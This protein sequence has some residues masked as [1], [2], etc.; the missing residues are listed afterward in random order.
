MPLKSYAW[1]LEESVVSDI[2]K[3]AEET[4]AKPAFIVS[5]ALKQY[6]ENY[7]L[8]QK[9]SFISSEII[10]SQK[11]MVDLL[12]HRIN[13]RA[14]QLLSSLAIQQFIICKVLAESLEISPDALEYYRK[15]GVEF[16]RENNRIF[17]LKEMLE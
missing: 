15:Q 17:G 6:A 13:N 11:S 12:E 16:M 5:Q 7:H 4:Q 3:I 1:R 8:K 9:S 2:Y 10:E 14:N